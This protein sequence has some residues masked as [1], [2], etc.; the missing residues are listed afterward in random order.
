MHVYMYYSCKKKLNSS[1]KDHFDSYTIPLLSPGMVSLVRTLP[2]YSSSCNSFKACTRVYI[3]RARLFCDLLLSRNKTFSLQDAKV[4]LICL[5]LRKP[6]LMW[7]FG[8][9]FNPFSIS[10]HLGCY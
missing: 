2:E 8:N 6:L 3:N 10:E 7:I 1:D 9:L 5:D 4:S